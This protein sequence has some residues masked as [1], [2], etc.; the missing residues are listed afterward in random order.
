[1][2]QHSMVGMSCFL[3][4]DQHLKFQVWRYP[5][6]PRIGI[7]TSTLPAGHAQEPSCLRVSRYRWT[8]S[9]T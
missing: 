2:M 8:P 9:Q 4:L 1:M 6:H 3:F 5:D 7:G